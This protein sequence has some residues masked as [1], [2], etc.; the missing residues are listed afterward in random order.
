MSGIFEMERRWMKIIMTIFENSQVIKQ[1]LA[2]RNKNFSMPTYCFA[3]SF[4]AFYGNFGIYW[5]YFRRS[6]Q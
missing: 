5:P 6:F 1:F 3:E 4:D 2:G